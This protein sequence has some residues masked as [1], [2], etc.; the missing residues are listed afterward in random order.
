MKQIFSLLALFSL[1]LFS[2]SRQVSQDTIP[3]SLDGKWRMMIVKDNASGASI[4]KPSSIPG[5]VDII[6]TSTNSTNGFFTGNTPTNEIWQ[7]DYA[8]TPARLITI[9]AVSMT[10]VMETSW[11]NE[12]VTNITNSQ[13]YGFETGGLLHIKTSTKTLTFLRL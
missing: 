9:P 1:I 5:E 4:T 11:G 12:F 6:F 7:S 13:E 8:V 10:K 2:C 3:T